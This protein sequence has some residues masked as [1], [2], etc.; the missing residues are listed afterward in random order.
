VDSRIQV[1][2]WGNMEAAAQNRAEYGK[3]WSVM[4]YVPNT[5]SDNASVKQSCDNVH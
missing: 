2:G 5:L 3:E 1:E 4:A